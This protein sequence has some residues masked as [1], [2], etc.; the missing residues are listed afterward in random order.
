MATWENLLE[1]ENVK[2]LPW[3]GGRLIHY[4]NRTWKISGRLPIEFGWYDFNLD[5]GRNATLTGPAEPNPDFE[6]EHTT[7][8]GYLVGNRLIPD[9]ARVE[10]DPD[11]LIEQ[12]L[13]VFLVDE[14]LERFSRAVVVR[15]KVGD[16]IYL[17][18]EFPQGPEAEVTEAY[19]DRLVSTEHIKGVTPALELAFRWSSVQ[20]EK[21]EER[22]RERLRI[23]E[24]EARKKEAEARRQEALKNIGTGAGRRALAQHDFNAA[25]KAALAL[26]GAVFLD[27][28]PDARPGCVVVKYRFQN[29]RLECVVQ[30]ET[31]GIVDAGF[32]LTDHDTGEKGDTYFTLESLPTVVAEAIRRGKLVIW[33]HG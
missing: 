33:R 12:T 22:E 26:S 31:L 9:T 2:A 24:E 16:H 8:Q 10:V 14:S 23:L 4:Q 15:T 20:R 11:K 5:G 30:K 17:R 21:A 18:Q 13:Q 28:R 19:E 3:V 7:V 29:Q 25:A 6:N 27:A 32:C 1:S